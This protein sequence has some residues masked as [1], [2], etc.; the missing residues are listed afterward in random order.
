MQKKAISRKPKRKGQLEK[1]GSLHYHSVS[2]ATVKKLAAMSAVKHFFS[3]RQNSS[4]RTP[5]YITAISNL[6][7][8]ILQTRKSTESSLRLPADTWERGRGGQFFDNMK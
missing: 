8:I 3:S 1:K 7:E 4:L 6:K 2:N 5:N